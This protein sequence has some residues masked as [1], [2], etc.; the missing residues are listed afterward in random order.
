M[1]KCSYMK[2]KVCMLNCL[3]FVWFYRD[4]L[5]GS[6]MSVCIMPQIVCS[7]FRNGEAPNCGLIW[8]L[9]KTEISFS[10]TLPLSKV[11][12]S[13]LKRLPNANFKCFKSSIIKTKLSTSYMVIIFSPA[14]SHM[15]WC[16]YFT[17]LEI[18][19]DRNKIY[20]F[21]RSLW[22]TSLLCFFTTKSVL[23][24]WKGHLLCINKLH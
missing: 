6:S 20:N 8:Y 15:R 9:W 12:V 17:T 1:L 21:C 16:C 11:R 22:D 7:V 19:G 4:Y 24:R 5:F 14:D 2:A 18:D 13:W 10:C 23:S 3:R